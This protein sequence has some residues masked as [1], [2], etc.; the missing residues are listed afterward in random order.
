MFLRS[1][2][3]KG[4]KS[5]PEKTELRFAPGVSVVVGPN[6]SGK[7]N[8]TDAVLWALGEQSPGAI[9][10]TSMQDVISVGGKNTGARSSAE[11][12]VVIDN[13]D[14]GIKSDFAE[15][16][17]TRRLDRAGEGEYRLNG[18]RCRLVDIVEILSDANLGKEMHSV[19]S[20]GRVDSVVHSKPRERR[21]LIE[22]AAGLGKF[23]K[24][25]RRAELKLKA[26]RD[27][28][29]RALDVEREA[30][31][32]L[33]PLK[34][35]ANAAEIGARIEL[36]ELG[37]RAQI[38]AEELRFG[39]DRLE[40]ARKAAAA[41]RKDRTSLE[42]SLS[43]VSSRRRAAEERFAERDRERTAIWGVLNSL[44]SGQEKIAISTSAIFER[45]RSLG[46]RL[47]SLRIE[48]APLTFD[49]GSSGTASERSRRLVEELSEV[50][51]GL[52]T[53]AE[54]L[55]QARNDGPEASRLEALNDVHTGA[56][57][58]THHARR[59]EGL[60]GERHR[61]RLGERMAE[62]EGLM[63]LIT[64]LQAAG[65]A[66]AAAVRE[67]V[68]RAEKTVIGDQGDADEI[69]AELKLC[70]EQEVE[71]Q[72]KLRAVAERVTTAEVEAAHLG[73]R[74]EE[75]STELSRI[76]EKLD[77]VI[78]E[79]E[80]PLEDAEREAIERRLNSLR[81]RRERLGPVNPLAQREYE[82]A[83]EHLEQMLAQREDT[84]RA[85]RELEGIIRDID[86]EITRSFNETFAATAENFEEMIG[87]LFPGGSGRLRSVDLRPAPGSSVEGE[88]AE[89]EEGE[90][91][92][93]EDEI[94]SDF[95]VDLEVTPAGKRM[96][97]MKLL[98]GGEKAMTALAF[99]FAVFLARPC[100]F[101]ILDEVE[102]ALDDANIT[103]FLE[104]VRRFSDRTQFIIVTHQKLTMDAAD[105][106]YGVSM[107]GDGVTKIVSRRL[108][109]ELE[110]VSDGEVGEAA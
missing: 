93:D 18:A 42:E 101:Y 35:Q 36:E 28:L 86:A 54:G 62:V 103:R 2:T 11:V 13:S 7:S 52:Q 91:E 88:E 107:G 95:G 98:S 22:E 3:M 20:Q 74:R 17:I 12:E 85:L 69:A 105:V 24:R 44:R 27:N 76:A 78:P 110:A 45:G 51:A 19:I 59:A 23:R 8:I 21:M 4:F 84:E 80:E 66:V 6:G 71:I 99:V 65:D 109:R 15:I 38:V 31:R 29:D 57:R 56:E 73:D 102:A 50:D 49:L 53:A 87:H 108:P 81:L 79:A 96:R 33:R 30:R 68:S 48:L 40:A 61:E 70:S 5:F 83:L 82:E 94:Q 67:R 60:L 64:D 41:A 32:V 58:A 90:V 72:S 26:T 37:L 92:P 55:R 63:A 43:G 39:E 106:L 16:A 46:S 25:R 100:P 89:G 104:M 97:Q 14:A 47:E 75:A 10:G 34:Q 1:V 77:R 9:R